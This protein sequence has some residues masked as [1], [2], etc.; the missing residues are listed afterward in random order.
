[1]IELLSSMLIFILVTVTL[2]PPINLVFF[3]LL[4]SADGDFIR[5]RL[6]LP[7]TDD[8][9]SK[10]QGVVSTLLILVMLSSLMLLSRLSQLVVTPEISFVIALLVILSICGFVFTASNLIYNR[11][12]LSKSQS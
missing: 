12:T 8:N 6:G 1:M 2:I 5:V 10:S 9:R 11:I 4:I 3:A 7:D